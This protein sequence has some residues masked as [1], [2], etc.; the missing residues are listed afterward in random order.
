MHQP[1]RTSHNLHRLCWLAA[2]ACILLAGACPVRAQ[3]TLFDD[4]FSGGSLNSSLWSVTGD[5]F[6]MQRTRFGAQPS[7]LQAEGKSFLRMPLHVYNPN[8]AY[9]GDYTSGTEIVSNASFNV[10]SGIEFE[11]NMRGTYIQPGLVFAFYTFG[12]QG[13]YPDTLNDEIDIETLGEQPADHLWLNAWDAWN[14]RY[15]WDDGIH[16]ATTNPAAAGLD[17]SQWNNYKVRWYNDRVEWYVN[18]VLVRRETVVVPA[19]P[20]GVRF[21]IWLPDSSWDAA[22]DPG[23]NPVSNPA[24]NWTYYYDIDYIRVRSLPPASGV[25]GNGSGLTGDYYNNSDFTSYALSRIDPHLDFDWGQYSPD[26]TIGADTFSVRWSGQVQA[27]YSENYTFYTRTDDGVRLWVNG[28]LLIDHWQTQAPTEYSATIPLVAGQKYAIRMDYYDDTGGAVAQLRWSSPST[29]KQL[30]PQAQLYPGQATVATPAFSPDGGAYTS[31]VNVRI[32]C[33]TPGATIHYTTDGS[34]PSELD[35]A[36]AS[37]AT[38]AINSAT[39]LRA[40]AWANGYT[41]SAIKNASYTIG[42]GDTTRPT[43]AISDPRPNFSYTALSRVT[44]TAS[45]PS[46]GSGIAGVRLQLLRYNDSTYWN[47][48]SWTKTVASLPAS[49]TTSWSFTLPALI[50]GKY[51]ALA[52]AI[53]DAGNASVGVG[54]TFTI[55]RVA[56]TVTIR[57]PGSGYSYRSLSAASGTVQDGAWSAGIRAVQVQLLRH[58]GNAYW[59]GGNWQSAAA[60]LNAQLSGSLWSFALPALNEGLYTLRVQASDYVPNFSAWKSADFQ[61]DRT[62]PTV[63]FTNPAA[64]AT[65]SSLSAISGN[66]F[67]GNNGS[68]IAHVDL[69]IMR[70]SDSRWWTGST[71]GA[72]TVLPA[73]VS[74]GAWSRTSALPSGANLPAGKYNLY[75]YAYDW[76]GNAGRSIITVTVA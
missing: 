54:V 71:W 6:P 9:T 53:D 36:I 34:Q 14:Q 3:Q 31:A 11:W 35:P 50:D 30:V 59:N 51:A 4:E 1:H 7:I 10:G 60:S 52:T 19:G 63:T 68:G 37:G 75:I 48:S 40:R 49:G 44:G 56:P 41:P 42:G 38:V 2:L 57:V 25:W 21:N 72:S 73:V 61:I 47:G 45:D 23:I 16:N 24:D 64:N 12:Q 70:W 5:S 17:W 18:D 69:F 43:V 22:F 65:V 66:V 58:S 76:A 20:M 8:P 32:T 15:G 13:T 46:P 26:T 29:P 27:Q 55:D 67:D 28:Q 62:P 74:S 39:T 33:S